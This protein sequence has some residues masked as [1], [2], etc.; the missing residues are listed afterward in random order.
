MREEIREKQVLE[1]KQVTVYVANDGEEFRNKEDCMEYEQSKECILKDHFNSIPHSKVSESD[2]FCGCGGDEDYI[3][4]IKPRNLADIQIMCEYFNLDYCLFTK[5][6]IGNECVVVG[7]EDFGYARVG[8]GLNLYI[9]I[10][11]GCIEKMR[12]EI[13]NYKE[14][15]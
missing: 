7:S 11:M 15:E 4:L 13:E 1:L 2:L 5:E 8:K 12:N 3:Y 14:S 9:D 6:D 10:F